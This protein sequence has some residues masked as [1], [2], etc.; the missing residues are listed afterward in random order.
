MR[1]YTG[2][3]AKVIPFSDYDIVAK[4]IPSSCFQIVANTV[5]AGTQVCSNPEDTTT[6]IWFGNN[7]YEP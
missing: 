4:S 2:L 5:T 7:P 1:K 3:E 6:H